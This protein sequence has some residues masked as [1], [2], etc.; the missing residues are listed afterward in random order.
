MQLWVRTYVWTLFF[1]MLAVALSVL[2]GIGAVVT[3][4]A[5][6]DGQPS[7][8]LVLGLLACLVALTL[9]WRYAKQYVAEPDPVLDDP[10]PYTARLVADLTIALLGIGIVTICATQ[11]IALDEVQTRWALLATILGG[12]FVA[13]GLGAAWERWNT[14]TFG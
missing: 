7:F 14:R 2:V 4:Q 12:P 3:A 11:I 5:T 6:I 9:W 1:E 13:L 8:V 10:R